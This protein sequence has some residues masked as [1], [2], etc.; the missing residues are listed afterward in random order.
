LAIRAAF[1]WS[2]EQNE[3]SSTCASPTQRTLIL[4]AGLLAFYAV[5]SVRAEAN[6]DVANVLFTGR[7]A[8]WLSGI[9]SILV[10]VILELC[11]GRDDD[12]RH[13][14]QCPGFHGG[15]ENRSNFKHHMLLQKNSSLNDLKKFPA[16]E[17]GN[18]DDAEAGNSIGLNRVF[19]R[20]FSGESRPRLIETGLAK[21]EFGV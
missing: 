15:Q 18:Y 2:G 11:D 17:T 9:A 6:I 20:Q 21:P 1:T 19:G 3:T 8:W 12:V 7:F 16:R 13:C 5:C 4:H 10:G 14:A